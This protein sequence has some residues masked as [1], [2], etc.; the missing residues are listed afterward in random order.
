MTTPA[1]PSLA[2]FTSEKLLLPQLQSRDM[3]GAIG[4][5]S[6]AFGASHPGW[7]TAALNQM[8]LERER[9]MSTAVEFGAA[10]PHVRLGGEAAFQEI[11]MEGGEKL[12]FALGHSAKPLDWPGGSKVRLVFLNVVPGA[13]AMGY[14]KLVSAMA[15]LGREREILE[16]I[17]KAATAAEMFQA[18]ARVPMKK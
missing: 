12:Q 13:D 10:F 3:A 15:R 8:A 4:E 17:H 1:A 16:Q 18:L 5:L 7:D 14:L 11:H 2:D 9:Q 6:A